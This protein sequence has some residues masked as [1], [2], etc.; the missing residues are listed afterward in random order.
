M[1][2]SIKAGSFVVALLALPLLLASLSIDF[3]S[4]DHEGYTRIVFEADRSFTFTTQ[5]H[6]DRL[7]L[8]LSGHVDFRAQ[9]LAVQNSQLLERV[10]HDYQG[11]ESV[12][13]VFFK[14]AAT[15]QKNFVLEKPFRV[16]FDLVRSER[17]AAAAAPPQSAPEIPEKSPEPSPDTPA[18]LRSRP[19]PSPSRRFASTPATAARIWGPSASPSYR[20]RTSPCRSGSS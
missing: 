6:P 17:P 4:F 7:E 3:R 18:P 16:V 1:K 15:V 8:R 12:F 20:K 5:N 13:T 2:K 9:S 10:T 14:G 11:G 19:S